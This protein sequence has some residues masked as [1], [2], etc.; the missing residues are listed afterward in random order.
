MTDL[1]LDAADGNHRLAGHVHH[2]ATQREGHQALL[3]KTQPARSHEHDIFRDAPF[4]ENLVDAAHAHLEGQGHVIRIGQR[5][6]AGSALSSVDGDKVHAPPGVVHHPGQVMPEAHLP[7]GGLDPH[8][9]PGGLRDGLHP[10]QHAVRIVERGVGRG[11]DAVFSHLNAPDRGDFGS[12]LGRGENSS[13][14]GLGALAELDF[15]GQ[16]RVLFHQFHQPLHA[17]RSVRRAAAEI[18]GADLH[19][20]LPAVLMVP[21]D[22]AFAGVVHAIGEFGA[23]V[24]RGDGVGAQGTEAHGRDIEG[25]SRPEGLGPPPR[26]AQHLGAGQ[27]VIRIVIRIAWNG[28]VQGK[29]RMLDDDVVAG[30][31]QVLVRAEAKIVV[32]VFR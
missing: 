7:H 24:E 1:G 10:V 27:P 3:G 12:D 18:G 23:L 4:G 5:S 17:E 26:L 11:A 22:A 9:Q 21:G 20:Q 32:L 31:L 19:H 13:L 25:R 15:D 30:V 29:G 8:W 6:G 28:F 16:H 2:V 14:G